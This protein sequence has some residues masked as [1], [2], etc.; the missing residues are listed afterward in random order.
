MV[1]SASRRPLAKFIS[2]DTISGVRV[3]ARG[4]KYYL[5]MDYAY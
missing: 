1:M 3:F 2:T 4:Q 5:Q